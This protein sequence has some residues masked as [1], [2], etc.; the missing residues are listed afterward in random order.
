MIIARW[1]STY[2]LYI[3][4][5]IHQI[6]ILDI[7]CAVLTNEISFLILTMKTFMFITTPRATSMI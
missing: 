5:P 7:D 1:I 3:P 4:N 6:N 2:T